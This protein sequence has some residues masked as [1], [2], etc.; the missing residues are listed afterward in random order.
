V[1]VRILVTGATGFIGRHLADGLRHRHEVAAPSRSELDLLDEQSVYCYLR[2]RRF[3]GVLH[4]ATARANRK[5]GAPDGLLNWN[6]RM[7]FN[8]AKNQDA[9]G[10]L[11]FLS[12]GAVYDRRSAP[13]MVSEEQFG[14]RIPADEYGCS[15]YICGKAVPLMH[16]ALD[17]RLFGVF[18]PH[19]DWEIR[20]LSNA[21]CRAIFGLPIVIRHNVRFDYLDVAD[22]VDAAEAMLGI[23]PRHRAYNVCR[24]ETIDLKSLA[25]KVVRVSGKQL[26][27]MVREPGIGAEY[28]GAN[29]RLREEFPRLRFRNLDD[30][31]ER[32]YSWY[33]QH[34][35][36][37]D[38]AKLNFDA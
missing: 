15:K 6:C 31:I 32:L 5:V 10:R 33:L 19:E 29:D 26:P 9:Y 1:L 37:I 17:L 27:V 16:D 25:A 11:L 13:P 21:C 38:P 35:E 20:F 23:E 36:S 3:D 4:S 34:R 8:L 24:G 22:V 12:S 18:G 30:S 7:F 14:V 28:S 2:K